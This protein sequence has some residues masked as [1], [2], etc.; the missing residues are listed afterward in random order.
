MLSE[1]NKR[2]NIGTIECLDFV[3]V[4]SYDSKQVKK[5]PTMY[6]LLA[7]NTV[8]RKYFSKLSIE[9]ILPAIGVGGTNNSAVHVAFPQGF[10]AFN[11]YRPTSS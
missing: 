7:M 2:N 5:K 1:G 9:S 6:S 8:L 4:D 11:V 10:S 3:E